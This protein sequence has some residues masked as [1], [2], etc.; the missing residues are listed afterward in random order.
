MRIARALSLCS[1]LVALS[2]GALAVS[3]GFQNITNN[4]AADA[5]T[6]EAQLL[7]DV[8]DAGGG[9]VSFLF[10]NLGPLAS[11]ITDVYFDDGTLLGIASIVNGAGVSFS[12]G[13]SPPDLPGGNSIS[14]AFQTSAGFSADSDPPT[15]PNGVNPGE[16]LEILFDLVGGSTFADTIAALEAGGGTGGLRVGIHVQGFAGGGSEAF[17]NAP[18]IPEPSS[19]LLAGFALAVFGG[20]L[21]RRSAD[22]PMK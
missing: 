20:A 4:N 17:V 14:P 9:Q 13:A 18:P 11:S 8:T 16:Q 12:Q 22:Q 15:Q 19:A 7:L 10:T 6:G 21:R 2:P 3:F 1:V 5:A